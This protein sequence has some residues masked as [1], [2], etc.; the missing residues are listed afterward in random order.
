MV[1]RDK[2]TM[3]EIVGTTRGT[4][5]E[6]EDTPLGMS[7]KRLRQDRSVRSKIRFN[8]TTGLAE[9]Y[10]ERIRADSNCD[11]LVFLHDD[12]WIDDYFL[13]QRVADGLNRF[14][15]IGIA[16]NRRLAPSHEGWAFV[17]GDWDR[18]HLS[19]AVAHGTE[20]CGAITYYGDC[21]AECELLDGVFLAAKRSV[22]RG[23]N[24]EFDSRFSFHLHD[25]DFCRAARKAG[26][27]LGT[28]PIA[29]TH[30]SGGAF[31]SPQWR[32]ALTMYKKKWSK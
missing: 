1:D 11:I 9:V 25:L 8:N 20:P 14:D 15:V 6:F 21:P 5:S 22:L 31:G 3:I 10:N 4:E 29:I 19:G 16:G 7:L 12:V 32:D 18:E 26:L 13:A 17:N 23:H 30:Q 27:K 2:Q 24:V 28:W